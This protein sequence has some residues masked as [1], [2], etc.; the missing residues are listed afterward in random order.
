MEKKMSPDA[1]REVTTPTGRSVFTGTTAS[2]LPFSFTKKLEEISSLQN[3]WDDE[4]AP[5]CSSDT[6]DRT[7]KLLK[8]IYNNHIQI[9]PDITLC[10]NGSI[11]LFWLIKDFGKIITN[12]P[13]NNKKPVT[14]YIKNNDGIEVE[15]SYIENESDSF[16]RCLPKHQ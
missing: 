8:V 13:S 10:I 9:I 6:Y 12:I 11:D 3:G 1:Q 14:F 15:G 5:A 2:R 16:V 7:E 4:D